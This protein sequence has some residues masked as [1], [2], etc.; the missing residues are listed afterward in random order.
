MSNKSFYYLVTLISLLAICPF[1]V[2]PGE[3]NHQVNSPSLPPPPGPK[4]TDPSLKQ[5]SQASFTV[6][7]QIAN[8]LLMLDFDRRLR[9]DVRFGTPPYC[10]SALRPFCEDPLRL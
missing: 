7:C 2:I 6:A 3:K 4:L 1:I 8:T 5:S 10:I 9:L